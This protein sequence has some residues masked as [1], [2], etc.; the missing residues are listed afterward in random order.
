MAPEEVLTGDAHLPVD[1]RSHR[2]DDRVVTVAELVGTHVPAQFDV[3]EEAEL[4]VLG[5]LLVD[6]ADG[7]DVRVV[8]RHAEADE[9]PRRRQPLE[10]VDLGAVREQVG[11]RVEAGG[12]GPHD[13]DAERV[14]RGHRRAA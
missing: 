11:G 4:G 6:P 2:I 5:R 1:L 13:G 10:H 14:G 8:G 9:A 12:A 7:L 3:A